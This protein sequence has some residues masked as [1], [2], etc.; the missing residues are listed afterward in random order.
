MIIVCSKLSFDLFAAQLISLLT[1][2]QFVGKQQ[3][4]GDF[5]E[6]RKLFLGNF[7]AERLLKQSS[8]YKGV[9]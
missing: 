8:I 1:L 2:T 9:L 3:L 5:P 7:R 6:S 4:F